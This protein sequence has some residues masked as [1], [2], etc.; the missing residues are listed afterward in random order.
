MHGVAP[1]T[2]M[3]IFVLALALLDALG[4][5][6]LDT[7]AEGLLA[8]LSATAYHPTCVMLRG[9]VD[10]LLFGVRPDPL[11]AAAQVA[12]RIGADPLVALRAI[13]E[14]LVVPCAALVV[15]DGLHLEVTDRGRSDDWQ[16]GVGLASMRERA[17]ELGGTLEA[18]PG[19][20]GGQVS[21]AA[22]LNFTTSDPVTM[23]P[24]AHL[25]PAWVS[26]TR[27]PS[28]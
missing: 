4:A 19:P 7:G 6:D 28:V 21:R 3:A 16:A 24:L 20:A 10:E 11:G 5:L 13:R 18:G 12:G 2:V 9:V 25:R 27:E 15:D 8:A 23:D 14:S 22:A 1:V 17:T 26:A